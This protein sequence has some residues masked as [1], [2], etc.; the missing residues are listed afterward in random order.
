MNIFFFS[1]CTKALNGILS[2]PDSQYSALM[3]LERKDPCFRKD[4]L[5]PVPARRDPFT[6]LAEIQCVTPKIILLPANQTKLPYY[7]LNH[8]KPVN[9]F[10]V[11]KTD[12]I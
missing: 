1:L 9:L 2:G 4:L 7:S 11:T 10:D 3:P 6:E 8:S 12:F 5:N